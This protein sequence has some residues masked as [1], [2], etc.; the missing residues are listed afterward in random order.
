MIDII[1]MVMIMMVMIMMVMMMMVTIM[2]MMIMIMVMNMIVMMVE[3]IF[4]L[5][6]V[7]LSNRVSCINSPL[8]LIGFKMLLMIITKMAQ[9]RITMIIIINKSCSFSH[10]SSRMPS[11]LACHSCYELSQAAIIWSCLDANPLLSSLNA[12]KLSNCIFRSTTY[13]RVK[14]F[15]V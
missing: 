9:M 10:L 6:F 1:M 14:F 7:S 5:W 4:L 8:P 13:M 11:I 3:N 12:F 2:I 15:E